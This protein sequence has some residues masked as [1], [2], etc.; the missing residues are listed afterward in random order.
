MR[1]LIGYDGSPFADA[2]MDDLQRAGLPADTQALVLAVADVWPQVP[3]LYR[4][5]AVGAPLDLSAEVLVANNELVTHAR[6]E[7]A[8]LAERARGRLVEMFPGWRVEAESVSDSP[9]SALVER[10]EQ[11]KGDLIVIGSHGRGALGRLIFGSISQ[12]VVRYA[13]CSVRVGRDVEDRQA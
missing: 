10:A 7:A 2:A 4:A 6:A 12:K 9:G 1:V 11:F 5:A 3:G 8:E 13:H